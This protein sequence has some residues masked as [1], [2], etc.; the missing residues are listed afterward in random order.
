MTPH[1]FIDDLGQVNV[2][3]YFGNHYIV[4]ISHYEAEAH[5]RWAEALKVAQR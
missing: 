5:A 1:F 2:W 4:G 3:S